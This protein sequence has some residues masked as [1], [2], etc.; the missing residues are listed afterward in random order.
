[1]RLNFPAASFRLAAAVAVALGGAAAA[2][3]Q[4]CPADLPLVAAG[5]LTMSI[6]ATIPPN[7]YI[8][9]SGKLAG[10]NVDLGNEIARR[11]C[12]T[13][14]YQNVSFEVQIPGLQSGRWDMINTGLYY[15]AERAKL[16]YLIPY[17]VNALA[18]VAADGNPLHITGPEQL[19]GHAVGVEIA[20]FE[21]KKL[22]EINDAQVTKGL[23]PMDIHVFNTYGD[24][25]A[26]LGARQIEAVFIGDATGKYYQD[27]GRFTMAATGLF[28]GTPG[29]F[30]TDKPELADAIVKVLDDMKADG[31]Y[32][33]LMK[34]A[35]KTEIDAWD[36]W[37]GK[38][39]AY[40]TTE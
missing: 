15:T 33:K 39:K 14:E 30:A 4:S 16:M 8:D 19:A 7:Q 9:K 38:F 11:L 10:L 29:A 1:M 18:I 12:L 2:S 20:G 32:D 31:T 21:E 40:H 3:A 22:R 35:G 26:A 17:S 37:D 25:F 34:A 28:P 13:P 24:T 23:K 36:Q 6:N 27:Q 5:K